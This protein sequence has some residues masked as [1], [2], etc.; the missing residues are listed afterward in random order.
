[1][2]DQLP[3]GLQLTAVEAGPS[4]LCGR[5][6]AV[7]VRGEHRPAVV[8][9]VDPVDPYLVPLPVARESCVEEQE[10][11]LRLRIGP[12][13]DVPGGDIPLAVRPRAGEAMVAHQLGAERLDRG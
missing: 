9:E 3:A 5:L 8:G 10:R 11:F 4:R 12:G 13:G 2:V 7:A 6:P 1:M